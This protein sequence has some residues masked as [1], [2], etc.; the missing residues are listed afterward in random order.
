MQVQGVV[1]DTAAS[2]IVTD[3]SSRRL[4]IWGYFGMAISSMTA[5]LEPRR[6]D[7]VLPLF[8]ISRDLGLI[9]VDE[10]LGLLDGMGRASA[11]T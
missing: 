2:V 10:V 4:T 9:A 7:I 5:E 11:P 1:R 3:Q 8:A 6:F